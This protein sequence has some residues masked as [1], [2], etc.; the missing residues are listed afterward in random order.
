MLT[1]TSRVPLRDL[2]LGWVVRPKGEMAAEMDCQ[3]KISLI[4]SSTPERVINIMK[5]NDR[6]NLSENSGVRCSYSR[7]RKNES[8]G[9]TE[10]PRNSA[11]QGTCGFYALCQRCLIAKI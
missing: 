4:T 1:S 2:A 7:S 11:F 10:E 6:E 5:I 9:D 3:K 8:H